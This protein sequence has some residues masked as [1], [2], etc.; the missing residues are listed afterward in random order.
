M[1]LA[2]A[3]VSPGK[4]NKLFCKW[5]DVTK[6]VWLDDAGRKRDIDVGDLDL[7]RYEAVRTSPKE[8]PTPAVLSALR[9][10]DWVEDEIREE[11]RREAAINQY[12]KIEYEADESSMAGYGDYEDGE[13]AYEDNE[14]AVADYGNYEDDDEKVQAYTRELNELLEMNENIEV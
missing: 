8:N 5:G 6:T 7:L 12:C 9:F 10:P 11:K 14:E 3:I 1:P 13:S 2:S 4:F